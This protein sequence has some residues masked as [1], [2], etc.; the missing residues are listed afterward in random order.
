MLDARL[1]AEPKAPKIL[2]GSGKPFRYQLLFRHPDNL[3]TSA[4]ITPWH[5]LLEFRGHG[6]LTILPPSVHPSGKQYRWY[7]RQSLESLEPPELPPAILEALRIRSQPDDGHAT[8]SVRP[9]KISETELRGVQKRAFAYIQKITAVQN[10]GGDAETFKAACY[11]VIDFDLPLE[12]ALPVLAKWNDTNCRPKWTEADLIHKLEEAEKRPGERGRLRGAG[13]N[14]H[15]AEDVRL[16][17]TAN[18]G[19]KV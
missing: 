15:P 5:P 6:G 12:H 13:S 7:E 3:S 14:S 17:N 18:G 4:K 9:K 19:V 11:L 1:G 2:T 8:G 10:N 16:T